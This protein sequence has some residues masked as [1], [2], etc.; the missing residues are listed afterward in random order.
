MKE[1][2]SQV[3]DYWDDIFDSGAV[4]LDFIRKGIPF[5]AIEKSIDWLC[6]NKGKILD[7][8]CGNGTL[9][10]R[11]V[12][13]SGGSGL[14]IDLS[15]RAIKQANEASNKLDLSDKTEFVTG[16][17][18]CLNEYDNHSFEGVILSNIVDNLL[19]SDGLSLIDTIKKKMKKGGRLFLKM[20]DYREKEK[21]FKAGALEIADNLFLEAEGIYLWNLTDEAIRKIVEGD[22][23]IISEKKVELMGTVNR[24]FHLLKR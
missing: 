4:K 21:M 20:N 19:P 12:F 24:S 15:N 2:Y 13:L 7:F 5:E 16:S 1:Q 8:G 11:A 18:E 22:F 9:L 23:R 17:I 10:L 14:G 6:Q 3:K